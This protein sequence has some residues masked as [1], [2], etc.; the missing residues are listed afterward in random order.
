[1]KLY[2]PKR[3]IVESKKRISK[4]LVIADASSQALVSVLDSLQ[5]LQKDALSSIRV[6]FISI[7]SETLM[8]NLGPN[9]IALLLREERE[10]LAKAKEYFDRMNKPYDIKV[11]IAPPWKP[12]LN[13]IRDRD[14]DHDLIILQGEFLNL[15]R[16]YTIIGCPYSQMMHSPK[17]SILTIN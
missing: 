1:M 12:V 7:L 10:T 3:T 14:G 13:E 4:V 16:E 9:V 8:K 5:T 15:W 2:A 6:I 17:Y 11:I